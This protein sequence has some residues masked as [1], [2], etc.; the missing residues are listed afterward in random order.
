MSHEAFLYIFD[1]V[2]M[3]GVVLLFNIVHPSE[4]NAWLRGGRFSTK[5]GLELKVVSTRVN[6]D[7]E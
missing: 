6:G 5:A 3:F 2:L 1:A 7:G 4:I